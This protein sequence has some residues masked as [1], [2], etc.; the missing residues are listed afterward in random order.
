M[1][2]FGLLTAQ[3]VTEVWCKANSGLPEVGQTLEASVVR[4]SWTL[5]YVL[6]SVIG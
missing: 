4:I 5:L 2:V 1:R 3:S 6:L